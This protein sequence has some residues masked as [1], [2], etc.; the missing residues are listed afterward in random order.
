MADRVDESERVTQKGDPQQKHQNLNLQ[1]RGKGSSFSTC[2]PGDGEKDCGV[3][4]FTAH[5][6]RCMRVL[7]L[8]PVFFLAAGLLV[9][10]GRWAVASMV[11]GQSAGKSLRGR[12]GDLP[13]VV[14]RGTAEER[15]EA[16]G[17]LAGREFAKMLSE[18]LVPVINRK[19]TN[20]WD[21][22]NRMVEERFSFPPE[23]LIQ[24]K[25][26]V[27]GME[28]LSEME[29]RLAN[30][31]RPVNAGDVLTFHALADL[32]SSGRVPLGACSSFSVWGPLTRDGQVMSGRNLD[33]HRFP[34]K[35][36]IFVIAQEPLEPGHLRTL[37][38][39]TPGFFGASTALNEQGVFLALHDERGLPT[40]TQGQWVARVVP[41]RQAIEMANR[42]SAAATVA[43]CL[44]RSVPALGGNVMVSFP[45]TRGAAN[46]PVVLEWD[47]NSM[48]HG[49]TIREPDVALGDRVFC[50]NHYLK[51]RAPES[52]DSSA[53]RLQSM[54]DGVRLSESAGRPI[55]VEIAKG[56]LQGASVRGDIS[57]Y[58]SVVASPATRE[59]WVAVAAGPGMSAT[60]GGW[61]HI[62]WEEIFSASS[63]PSTP[64]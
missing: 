27:R 29:R 30:L 44:R 19:A 38:V 45:V 59:L 63:S 47:G 36:P 12:L 49:V 56:L 37:E 17:R 32:I 15:A 64:Q 14:L 61:T 24:A 53:R 18:A 9:V 31:G 22:L 51:R 13:V 42:D 52:R 34:G 57:T 25:A 62:R 48:D 23:F 35:I 46:T 10:D 43:E 41:L 28:G 7:W 55:D 60:D 50:T 1:L 54:M 5:F 2:R 16:F 33:Y 21:S 3:K 11:P 39:S 58:L 26:F 6:T 20:G 8:R 4:I 40:E